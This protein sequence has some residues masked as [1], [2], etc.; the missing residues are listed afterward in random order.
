MDKDLPELQK[1]DSVKKSAKELAND[2]MAR[3]KKAD[4]LYVEEAKA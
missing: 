1:N 3:K 4:K 2:M